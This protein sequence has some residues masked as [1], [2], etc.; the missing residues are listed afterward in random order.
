MGQKGPKLFGLLGISD[1]R[2]MNHFIGVR[3]ADNRPV[4]QELK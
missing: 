3:M 4:R 1:L 2:S